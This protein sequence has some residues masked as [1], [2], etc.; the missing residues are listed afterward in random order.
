LIIFRC[1]IAS[2][3]KKKK[4]VLRIRLRNGAEYL[5]QAKDEVSKDSFRSIALEH[6]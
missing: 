3:Y 6:V 5:L 2:D 4:Y 1:E